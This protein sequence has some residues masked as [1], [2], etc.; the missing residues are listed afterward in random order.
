MAISRADK[1]CDVC[2][3][4]LSI[5]GLLI[6]DVERV[7]AKG[8]PSQGAYIGSIFAICAGEPLFLYEN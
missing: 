6:S 1:G 2:K 7:A 3:V 5:D 4:G 8:R